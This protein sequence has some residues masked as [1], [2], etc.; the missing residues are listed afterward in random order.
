VSQKKHVDPWMPPSDLES[1][2]ES[3]VRAL[4]FTRQPELHSQMRDRVLGQVL[5]FAT[6]VPSKYATRYRSS[7][8]YRLQQTGAEAIRSVVLALQGC[9][10]TRTEHKRL[11][12]F[13]KT[14]QGWDRYIA[15]NIQVVDTSTGNM[16]DLR[17]LA[18]A[19]P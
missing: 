14:H 5:W 19:T 15:A 4:L 11:Q 12:P 18:A 2:I 16:A 6:E 3:A 10:V 17:A 9:V 13:D 1:R 7:E 8:A